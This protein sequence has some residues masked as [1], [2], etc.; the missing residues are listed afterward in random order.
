METIFI[1]CVACIP[2][3]PGLLLA[4]LNWCSVGLWVFTEDD[5]RQAA[6]GIQF[7]R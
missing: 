3:I 5:V 7:T 1:I 6:A 2:L 4:L